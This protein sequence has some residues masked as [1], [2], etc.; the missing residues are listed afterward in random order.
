MDAILAA[1]SP[2][3][4]GLMGQF[5]WLFQIITVLGTFRLVFKPL[6]TFL[7]AI[8]ASNA[9]PAETK[10]YNA[11]MASPVYKWLS[12]ALDYVASLKLPQNPSV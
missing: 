12:F 7:A 6:M 9:I 1:L 8:A 3:F 10:A 2:V 11:F 5:G 4:Q